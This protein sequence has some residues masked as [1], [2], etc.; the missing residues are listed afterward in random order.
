MTVMSEAEEKRADGKAKEAKEKAKAAALAPPPPAPAANARVDEKK[1]V[2]EKEA[3]RS[4]RD[5]QVPAGEPFDDKMKRLTCELKGLFG[6]SVK[7]EAAIRK[8][9][10]AIGYEV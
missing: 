9:L 7:L 8:N 5:E 3:V 1:V 6:E 2:Q 10:K 4:L